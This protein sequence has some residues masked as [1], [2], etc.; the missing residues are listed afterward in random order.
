MRTVVEMVLGGILTENLTNA[1]G[2]MNETLS[3]RK[4]GSDAWNN[5]IHNRYTNLV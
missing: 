3:K 2:V 4:Q 1:N 5:I